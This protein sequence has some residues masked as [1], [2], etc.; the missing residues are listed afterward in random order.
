[1]GDAGEVLVDAEDRLQDRMAELERKAAG[2][3]K[4][5]VLDPV[6]ERTLRSLDLARAELVNQ[7]KATTHPARRSGLEGAIAE[8]DRRL[9]TL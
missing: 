7:M 1:M 3:A 6:R 2:A 8:I 5:A 4:A 9:T